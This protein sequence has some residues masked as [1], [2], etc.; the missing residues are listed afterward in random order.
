MMGAEMRSS[1]KQRPKSRT[2]AL[3]YY[4]ETGATVSEKSREP[5]LSEFDN[6]PL[7]HSF[8]SVST[9]NP[10]AGP[11]KS[12]YVPIVSRLIPTVS[13]R[14]TLVMAAPNKDVPTRTHFTRIFAPALI[15]KVTLRSG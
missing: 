10:R 6:G 2:I 4:F 5:A 3:P 7:L 8:S 15:S 13:I 12:A 14:K 1:R 9:A 11:S